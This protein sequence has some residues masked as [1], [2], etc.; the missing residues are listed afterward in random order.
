MRTIVTITGPTCSGKSTLERELARV[1]DFQPVVSST[2]RQRREGEVDGREYHFISQDAFAR[3]DA[4]GG[5]IE[6]ISFN[7]DR[8]GVTTGAL[9]EATKGGKVA[10]IV[11]EPHGA[12]QVRIFAHEHGHRLHQVFLLPAA[13]VI[14]GRFI[15]RIHNDVQAGRSIIGYVGRLAQI[16][17]TEQGWIREAQDFQYDKI[18]TETNL[19]AMVAEVSSAVRSL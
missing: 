13:G 19:A 1:A 16:L 5:L 6:S 7:G 9:A 11:C 15:E 4:A 14:A 12:K 17:S 2:T 10:T 18:I 8:Y 3:I